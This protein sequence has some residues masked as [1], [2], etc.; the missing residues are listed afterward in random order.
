MGAKKY[1]EGSILDIGLFGGYKNNE[2]M[3]R[4]A[5]VIKSDDMSRMCTILISDKYGNFIRKMFGAYSDLERLEK[6][7]KDWTT[8]CNSR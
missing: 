7:Y 8:G 4:K 2:K 1:I 3:V 6:N 5:K